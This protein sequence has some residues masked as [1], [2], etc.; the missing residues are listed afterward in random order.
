MQRDAQQL[1]GSDGSPQVDSCHLVSKEFE[2]SK[3]PT[4][5][6]QCLENCLDL[7]VTMVKHQSIG[8]GA[9]YKLYA[10]GTVLVWPSWELCS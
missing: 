9:T 2:Q 3:S 6:L 10:A 1:K 7:K 5:Q 8:S 4:V